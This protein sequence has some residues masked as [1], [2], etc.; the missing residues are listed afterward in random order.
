MSASTSTLSVQLYSVRERLDEDFLGTLRALAD[1]GFTQV[2][3]FGFTPDVALTYSQAFAETGLSAPTTHAGILD[4]P[5]QA[6]LFAAAAHAGVRT[7]ILP[8]SA[9]ERWTDAAGLEGI[10]ADLNAAAALASEHEVRVGYHNH[11]WELE[12]T[13]D[14]VPALEAL[15]TRLDDGVVLEVDTY[16]AEVGGVDAVGL[17]GRLGERVVAIHVKDGDRSRDTKKQQPAR[18]GDVPVLDILAAAP[19]ALRVIEF[20]DYDGDRLEGIAAS[21]AYLR[22]HG[23]S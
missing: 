9:Q 19:D 18:P 6:E 7:V 21:V 23:I 3:P 14:G 2:E 11:W 10:A 22:E 12:N 16:W 15:A 13:V 5:D 20:D 4:A 1:L 8:S 17:L